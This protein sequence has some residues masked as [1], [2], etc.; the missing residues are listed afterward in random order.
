MHRSRTRSSPGD[1]NSQF[2]I[3]LNPN[4]LPRY[5]QKPQSLIARSKPEGHM[6]HACLTDWSLI[7]CIDQSWQRWIPNTHANFDNHESFTI[8][9]LDGHLSNCASTNFS[10]LS[11]NTVDTRQGPMLTS[12][13]KWWW[14]IMCFSMTPPHDS[15]L[16]YFRQCS[17]SSSSSLDSVQLLRFGPAR[18]QLRERR[19]HFHRAYS[20][21][22]GR[23]VLGGTQCICMHVP[24]RIRKAVTEPTAIAPSTWQQ[25]KAATLKKSSQSILI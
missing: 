10:R 7:G 17:S 24:N 9:S 13:A 5:F 25:T 2:L 18:F 16:F 4:T 19:G 20:S 3:V 21:R 1:Y 15:K 8:R 11:Q 6:S 12:H 14:L 23:A 22:S